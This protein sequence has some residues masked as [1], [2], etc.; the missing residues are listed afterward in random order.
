M[1]YLEE[2]DIKPETSAELLKYG[3]PFRYDIKM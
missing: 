1:N 3:L 2:G